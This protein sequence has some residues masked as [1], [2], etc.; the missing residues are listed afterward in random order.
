MGIAGVVDSSNNEI[1]STALIAALSTVVAVDGGG[2]DCIFTTSYNNKY[3]HP[4][5][6][7]PCPH[8]LLDKDWTAGW[9]ACCDV[10]H[11][12]LPWLS[13]LAPSLPPLT[14]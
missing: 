14:G 9:R 3:R 8:P 11:S 7:R 13:S 5:P 12:L 4:C 1:D 10:S 2:K 6:H